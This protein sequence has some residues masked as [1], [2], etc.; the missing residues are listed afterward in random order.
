MDGQPDERV[1]PDWWLTGAELSPTGDSLLFLSD[2]RQ[3]NPW[4]G[5]PQLRIYR[6]DL[7]DGGVTPLTDLGY[8]GVTPL[9]QYGHLPG[10]W[11]PDGT[12]V[13][14]VTSDGASFWT[15]A[16]ILDAATGAQT[17]LGAGGWDASPWSADG[18]RMLL[19]DGRRAWIADGSGT[20]LGEIAAAPSGSLIMALGWSPDGSWAVLQTAT[21]SGTTPGTLS[22]VSDDGQQVVELG[23]GYLATWQP[24][25]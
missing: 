14:T 25:R 2:E 21:E 22:I 4:I 13:A 1:G 11:S 7:Y 23:T 20:P 6:L 10:Y 5:E 8:Y 15:D 12:R 24:L 17:P 19:D 18:A 3:A 16:L 9:S